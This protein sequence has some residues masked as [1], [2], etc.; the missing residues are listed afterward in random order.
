MFQLALQCF[1]VPSGLGPSKVLQGKTPADFSYA[2]SEPSCQQYRE[3]FLQ[4][5]FSILP[6]FRGTY[7]IL[8]GLDTRGE[9]E[10]SHVRKVKEISAVIQ[11]LLE[12]DFG[13]VSIAIFSRPERYLDP[14]FDLADVSIRLLKA[15]PSSD[16]L[17]G[18]CRNRVEGK[19]GPEL[20]SA[21]FRKPEIWL[22]DIAEA[23]CRASDGL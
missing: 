2:C 8:D 10:Y 13:N 12:Q 15:E 9:G 4:T 23:I 1:C 19:V 18:Y 14:L 17:S 11:S 6:N 3:C 5:L 7:I 21:G 16:T 22:D 20:V